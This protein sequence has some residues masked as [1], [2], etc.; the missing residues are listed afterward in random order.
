MV[1]SRQFFGMAFFENR[2]LLKAYCE[3]RTVYNHEILKLLVCISYTKFY[4]LQIR[5][6]Y[7][8][9]KIDIHT[10]DACPVKYGAYLQDFND[11][12]LT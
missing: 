10:K 7:N 8:S 12:F 2:I 9:K 1:R 3:I 4:G 5:A 6:Y 11:A